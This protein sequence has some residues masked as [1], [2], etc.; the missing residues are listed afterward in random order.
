MDS[1]LLQ[2]IV[3]EELQLGTTDGRK[4]L[5]RAGYVRPWPSRSRLHDAK[6]IHLAQAD[7]VSGFLSDDI[8]GWHD[9]SSP[10]VWSYS[11]K[12]AE[13]IAQLRP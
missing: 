6:H 12:N 9:Q 5:P 13:R 3:P 8:P 2:G 10:Y 7:S 1:E 11:T 4:R